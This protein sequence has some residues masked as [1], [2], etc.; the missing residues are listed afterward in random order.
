MKSEEATHVLHAKGLRTMSVSSCAN[1]WGKS[2]PYPL[3]LWWRSLSPPY[4]QPSLVPF[5]LISRRL[6]GIGDTSDENFGYKE[7]EYT[8]SRSSTEQEAAKPEKE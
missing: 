6:V 7:I 4:R 3:Q 8:G 1:T 2:S 5:C